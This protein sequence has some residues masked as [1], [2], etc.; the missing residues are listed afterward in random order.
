MSSHCCRRRL[1]APQ[2]ALGAANHGG[3]QAG[4]GLRRTPLYDVHASRG[5]VFGQKFGW[6]RVNYF[7]PPGDSRKMARNLA[8]F[9]VAMSVLAVNDGMI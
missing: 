8:A 2:S 5:A 4:R 1:A 7:V 9:S 6:E 3:S